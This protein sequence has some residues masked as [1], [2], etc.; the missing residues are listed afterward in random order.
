MNNF[1][2]ATFNKFESLP[3]IPYKI[4]AKLLENDNLFKLLKYNNYE[5]LSEPNLTM[6]EKADMIWKDQTNMADFYVY[7]TNVEP[8]E[9]INSKTILKIY[10]YDNN[11]ITPMMSTISYRLDIL[12]GT[13]N[14]LVN[15]N[16]VPCPRLDMIE[17][18]ILNSLNGE[19]VA[20]VGYLQFNH[21][22]SRSCRSMMTIGNNYTFTGTTMVMATQLSVDPYDSGC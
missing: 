13:K 16:G 3:Y 22:L 1:T 5:C 4:A 15:Y 9:L 21:E 2:S 10:K 14:A 20:G 12:C 8:D 6:E 19:D 7:L 18:E 11:P 17:M